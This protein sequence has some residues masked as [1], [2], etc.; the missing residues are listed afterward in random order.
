MKIKQL[1]IL[2]LSIGF[3]FYQSFSYGASAVAMNKATGSYGYAYGKKTEAEAKQLAIA[4]CPGGGEV[5]IS[6]AK[7]GYGA[8]LRN[9]NNW[10]TEGQAIIVKG[11]LAQAEPVGI[12]KPGTGECADCQILD[13]WFDNALSTDKE[14]F[15]GVGS[16]RAPEVLV[17]EATNRRDGEFR[18][19]KLIDG[20][21]LRH[22]FGTQYK[23]AE[24]KTVMTS[25]K[26]YYMGL[27]DGVSYYYSYEEGQ[28]PLVKWIQCFK[29][30]W[31]TGYRLSYGA[32]K[33]VEDYK[34]YKKGVQDGACYEY[35][36]KGVIKKK[37]RYKNGKEHGMCY[38]YLKGVITRTGMYEF[39]KKEGEWISYDDDGKTIRKTQT[40]AQGM[41]VSEVVVPKAP[42]PKTPVKK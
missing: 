20:R 34:E 22:G 11:V 38:E 31:F 27:R 5:I 8:V 2:I 4:N 37:M 21:E 6:S 25:K 24:T 30:G 35:D 41:V 23:D 19:L 17:V 28:E 16:R 29:D 36:F 10:K 40:Y 32:T 39:G 26:E 42:K 7:D 15:E 1:T 18:D 12:R 13:I 33:L 3:T 9:V 14:K